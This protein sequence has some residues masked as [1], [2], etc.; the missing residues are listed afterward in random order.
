MQMHVSAAKSTSAHDRNSY[1]KHQ[2]TC[3]QDAAKALKHHDR[4][5][6]L[7]TDTTKG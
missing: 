5:S 7:S 2:T 1:H 4:A 6:A 3:L